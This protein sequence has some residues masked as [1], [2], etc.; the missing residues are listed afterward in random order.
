M[1]LNRFY[2]HRDANGGHPSLIYAR[3]I[4]NDKY[5]AVCFTSKDGKGRTKLKHS[6]NSKTREVTYVHNS[7][8]EK[9]HNKFKWKHE[10]KGFSI[11]KDDKPL[12]ESIKKKK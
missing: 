12:I 9:S 4:N 8:I 1:K 6:I 7:P 5:K 2:T 11:K 10:L 3:D